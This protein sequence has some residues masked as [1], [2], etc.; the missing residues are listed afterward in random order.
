MSYRVCDGAVGVDDAFVELPRLV[1]ANDPDWIPEDVEELRRAFSAVNPW[2]GEGRGR[3]LA[4]C[5]PGR[6]RLAVFRQPGCTVAGGAAAFFGYWEEAGDGAGS[7][8]LFA[9]AEECARA[10]GATVML[11]PVNFTTHGSYRLR[12]DAS[13]G[14][15]FPG[16][17]YNPARYPCLLERLGYEPAQWYV[18]QL[19]APHGEPLAAKA[20]RR[21]A[22]LDAGYRVESLDSSR[23]M[24]ML[25]EL[26]GAADEIFGDAFAYT[27]VPYAHF[28]AA[29][30]A[31]VA[32]RLCPHTSLVARDAEGALAGFLLAYPQYGPLVVQ[33]SKLGRVAAS[34]LRY[35]EHAALLARAG[36]RTAIIKTVGVA[37]VHR[38]RGLM[39]ALAV[40]ALERGR[41]HYDRWIAALMRADNPSRRFGLAHVDGQRT[42]VLYGKPLLGGSHV[43]RA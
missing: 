25:P 16:E 3:A 41:P 23:W 38:R 20:R 14:T 4:L 6:A 12:V 37:K 42:Y 10:E 28:A 22:V 26:H 5:A 36:E 35:D 21:D 17:P 7:A 24:A 15:P 29:Y 33:G 1:Y 11:G 30:G 40:T 43:A 8:A 27:P 32:R 34:A 31:R 9:A 39:D 13:G 18:T 19:G 2:F